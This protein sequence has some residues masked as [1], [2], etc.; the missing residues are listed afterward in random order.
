MKIVVGLGNPGL[1]Y[2]NTRHNAGFMVVEKVAAK[3]GL[4]IK[5]K[6]FGGAYGAGRVCDAEVMFFEPLTYMNLSGEAVSAVCSAKLEDPKE[7]LVVSDDFNIPFGSIRLRSS[8]S[9]GGHNGLRSI[10][11]HMGEGFARLRVGI[12]SNMPPE[13][14]MSGFV[15]SR[16]SKEERGQLDTILDESVEKVELWL[17]KGVLPSA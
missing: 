16:F 3:H 8:G 13:G 12:G 6:G 2:R 17:K 1:R 7:L 5:K 15:L 10:I 11:E 4:K 9:A 14:D